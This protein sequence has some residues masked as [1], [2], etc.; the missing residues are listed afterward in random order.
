MLLADEYTGDDSQ[1][2]ETMRIL[3]MVFAAVSAGFG[4]L[5]LFG[6]ISGIM[7]LTTFA[8]GKVPMAPSTALLFLLFGMTIFFYTLKPIDNAARR[9]YFWIT[10]SGTISALI[11]LVLFLYG[12]RLEVEHL[13]IKTSESM[14]GIPVGHMSPLTA[15]C[16]MLCGFSLLSSLWPIP[17][18]SYCTTVALFLAF[19]LLLVST[20]LILGYIIGVPLLYGSAIIPPALTTC[21]AFLML[22]LAL[23]LSSINWSWLNEGRLDSASRQTARL[24]LLIFVIT[25]ASILTAA[26]LYFHNYERYFS[27]QVKG[28]LS[29]IAELKVENLVNWRMERMGDA[30]IFFGNTGFAAMVHRYFTEPRDAD[31]KEQLRTWLANMASHTDCDRVSLLDVH[32]VERMSVPVK[33]ESI[34]PPIIQIVPKVLQSRQ[35]YFLDFYRCVNDNPCLAIVVPLFTGVHNEKLGVLAF[36][37]DPHRYLYSNLN[38]WPTPSPTAETLL[39]R[40]DENDILFLNELRFRK[41]TALTMRIPLTKKDVPSVMAAWGKE[42]VVQGVDY[43]GIPVIAAILA[44]PGTPWFL[45][46][47]IDASEVYAPV[48]KQLLL[49][50]VLVGALLTSTGAGLGYLWRQQSVRYYREK[51]ASAAALAQSEEKF[52]SLFEDSRDAI[53]TLDPPDWKFTSCNQATLKMFGANDIEDFISKGPWDV[54]PE[55]QPDGIPSVDKAGEAIAAAVRDGSLLFEWTH[56]RIN[57]DEFPSTV[58]LTKM[59][60]DGHIFLQATVRDITEQKRAEKALLESEEKYRLLIDYANE[61]IIVAQDGLL[62]FVNPMALSLLEGYAE[63]D[64]IEK[65]FIDFIYPDDRAMVIENHRRRV[66]DEVL[67]PRYAF[68]VVTYGGSIKWVELNV[69]SIL[70]QGRPATLIF[71]TDITDRKRVE[72]MLQIEREN[73]KA[74]FASS[75]VGM[76]LLDDE[77]MIVDSNSVIADM[78]TRNNDDVAH[79]RV[80]NGIGCVHSSEDV[81]GCGFSSVCPDCALRQTIMQVLADGISIHGEEIQ[82]TLLIDDREYRPWLRISAEPVMVNGQ[83]HVIVAIDDVTDRK[84][85]E[86]ALAHAN[87][88]TENLNRQLEG[89]LLHSNEYAASLEI[90]KGEIEENALKL[91][92]QATHDALTGLHNRPYFEYHLDELIIGRTDKELGSFF[93]QFLDL[94]KLKLVNDTLG[95]KV[96]DLLLIEVARR[97]KTCL[98]SEDVIARLGGDEFTMILAN[99]KDIFA[100]QSVASR[101]IEN[102]KRPFEIDGHEVSIGASIGMASYP[103]DGK[104]TTTLLKHADMA[105][106]KAKQ[107]GGGTFRWYADE[108]V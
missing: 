53:M 43:R 62:K 91:S 58:S 76:L 72:E 38:N 101:M 2:H 34:D 75:P 94:D 61:S 63:P 59:D 16:F 74:I 67:P 11:L 89:A 52:R 98:R 87:A 99:C 68:R 82:T 56:K 44:V 78:I 48:R 5:A 39:I 69:A 80:G 42:G 47:K 10:L 77:M 79:M 55:L 81:R 18:R 96:G 93:V 27:V 100:A 13:G 49:L 17:V 1:R 23:I 65:P 60:N 83:K 57:G 102:I 12:V 19:I 37:I 25:S 73:L 32:G 92:H 33:S 22:G 8:A 71:F 86:E 41:G 4:L 64:V 40:R 30:G 45:V 21:L 20:A 108:T 28:E 85:I 54:S 90:A 97:L 70:W 26:Y 36:C 84:L 103:S 14:N 3:R 105:M 95:H 104:D 24:L 51:S 66:M 46:A 6:W 50:L 107:A 35:I 29:A 15:L 9:I 31:S 106:Y 7:F 88:V